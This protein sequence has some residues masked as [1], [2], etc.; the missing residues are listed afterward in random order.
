MLLDECF[1]ETCVRIG[2]Q[3]SFLLARMTRVLP[4]SWGEWWCW[5]P[6][7]LGRCGVAGFDVDAQPHRPAASVCHP[8]KSVARM[9]GQNHPEVSWSGLG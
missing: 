7:F 3:A 1:A 9:N 8:K 5:I 2:L 6:A 4:L